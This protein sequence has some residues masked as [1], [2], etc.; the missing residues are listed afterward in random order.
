[1]PYTI[2]DL[3]NSLTGVLHGTTTNQVVGLDVL[4]DRAARK[5]LEDLD[6]IETVRIAQIS[7]SIF[8]KVYDYTC[9]T[10]L[11][12]DRISDI[13]PQVNRLPGN[14][15]IQRYNADFDANKNNP[16][17]YNPPNFTV[18]WNTAVKSIRIDKNIISPILVNAVNTL[19]DTG[20]WAA[21]GNATDLTVDNLN[22]VY[23]GGSLRF[24]L[25]VGGTSGYLENSTMP[26]VD[27]SR[28]DTQ[29]TEFLWVYIPDTAVVTNF[30]LRWGSSSA[31]Y[32]T[33]TTTSAFN[34]TAFQNGWNLVSFPWSSAT[35]F[36]SPD[37]TSVTYAR[38]EVTYDGTATDNFRFNSLS[39]QLGAIYEIEYY[40]KFLF[41][42]AMGVFQEN[43]DDDTNIINLD[44]DSYN[45]FFSLVAL[46]CAQ[47]V[48]GTN[49]AFD[50]QFFSNEYMEGKKRYREKIKSQ[51]LKPK[52]T[53]YAIPKRRY[54]RNRY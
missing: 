19:T 13:R 49:S 46:Y 2:A 16:S 6:P 34:S 43:V 4:I 32:W 11:K 24:N 21:G 41:R 20:T 39:S 22:Y 1:M 25:S 3:K 18:Q 48:Q 36:G 7:P 35:T 12:G 37:E 26:A 44:T 45:V 15:F 51:V 8:S 28:D 14:Q 9:P 33:V 10:D 50:V 47:Q 53:Y 31:D 23:A 42:S 54:I 40:S 30:I 5:F 17:F 27:L 38:L 52:A 29:G